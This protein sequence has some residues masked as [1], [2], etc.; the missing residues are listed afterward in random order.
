LERVDRQRVRKSFHLGAEQYD[1]HTPVQQLVI[2]QLLKIIEQHTSAKKPQRIL[3]IG[4]G[5]GRL[6]EQVGYCYQTAALAGL[7]LAP[8]MIKQ[9]AERLPETVCLMHGDAEDLPFQSNCFDLVLSSS[10]FQWLDRL[11]LCFSEVLRVLEPD[12]QFL[13]SLFGK[14]TLHELHCSWQQALETEGMENWQKRTGGPHCFHT[15]EQVKSSLEATGFNSV[16]VWSGHE[17]IWYS[18]VPQLLQ[19]IRKIGAATAPRTPAGGGL[20]WRR[21]LHLMADIYRKQFGS[22]DG[23]PASYQVIYATGRR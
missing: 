2:E 15:P 20:G 10:T 8:N 6:L 5:T 14:G 18:D 23:V 12:G 9:A 19:A 11:N 17:R 4:C 3:D 16:K 1:Q 13:F 22:A 21:V 7:D